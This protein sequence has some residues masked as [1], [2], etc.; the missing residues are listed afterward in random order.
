MMIVLLVQAITMVALGAYFI[1]TGSLN[2]GVA[3]ILL[4][5]VTVLIY[6]GGIK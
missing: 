6:G 3:Q 4:A 5:V 1:A 2:L